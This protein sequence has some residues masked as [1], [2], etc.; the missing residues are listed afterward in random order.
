[1]ITPR[2]LLSIGTRQVL[3]HRNRYYGGIIAIA[4]GTCGFIVVMTLGEDIKSNINRDLDLLG[5]VTMIKAT[6]RRDIPGCSRTSFKPETVEAVSRLPGVAMV[7]LAAMKDIYASAFVGD[8]EF[9]FVLVAVDDAFWAAGSYAP[10][11]GRFFSRDDVTERRKVCVLGSVLANR[12]FGRLPPPGQLILIDRDYYEIIGYLEGTGV[13]DMNQF[14]FLPITTAMSRIDRM[15][16]KN[17]LYVRCRT[18]DDVAPVAVSMPEVIG[19]SQSTQGLQVDMA[20]AQLKHIK[21][22]AWWIRLFVGVSILATLC[23][24]GTGIWYGMMTAVRSR[25]REIGLKKAMGATRRDIMAQFLTESLC[26]SI[27]S[28]IIGVV[29]GGLVMLII[30]LMLH[31][32]P[33]QG[34]FLAA[35]MISITISVALG[36]AAGYYPSAQA[37]RLEVISAVRFE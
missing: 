24:G 20:A 18:W 11:A 19:Q 12:I 37:A 36:V 16:P 6:F 23:L 28:T 29:L 3:R 27:G 1:M 22:I 34:L 10:R 9:G 26:L 33:S 15:T 32:L 8:R 25:T 31:T 14:A 30:S 13:G 21:R 7:S 4:L 17:K 5:G 35:V 2:D